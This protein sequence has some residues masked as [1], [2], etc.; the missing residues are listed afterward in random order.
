MQSVLLMEF[1]LLGE[2]IL[3]YL[4]C[5]IQLFRAPKDTPPKQRYYSNLDAQDC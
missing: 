4:I 5:W 3:V 2:A 1:L